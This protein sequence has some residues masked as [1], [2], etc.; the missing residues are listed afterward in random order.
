MGF[1]L[2]KNDT[3]RTVRSWHAA[4]QGEVPTERRIASS[5]AATAHLKMLMTRAN[6]D[7]SGWERDHVVEGISRAINLVKVLTE[8]FIDDQEG[9]SHG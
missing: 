6:H 1:E 9:E 7:L 2:I 5:K 8:R 4:A 3:A